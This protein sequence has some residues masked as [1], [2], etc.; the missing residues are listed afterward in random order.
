M[1][2]SNDNPLFDDTDLPDGSGG[3][4]G[5]VVAE[6]TPSS[7]ANLMASLLDTNGTTSTTTNGTSGG[8]FGNQDSN[9]NA[10]F[11]DDPP[12]FA[13]D[14]SLAVNAGKPPP[15][16][17]QASVMTTPQMPTQP[18]PVVPQQSSASCGLI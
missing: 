12:P 7:N 17:T 5:S 4:G 1:S 16:P 8:L 2:S 6:A 15:A 14:S 9:D 10:L 3:T 11:A 18:P 13:T